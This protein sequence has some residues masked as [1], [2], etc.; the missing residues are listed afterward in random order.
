MCE[1]QGCQL[2]ETLAGLLEH[3]LWPSHTDVP[4]VATTIS[5]TPPRSR[6]KPNFGMTLV[7]TS[8]LLGWLGGA[9]RAIHWIFMMNWM[10]VIRPLTHVQLN[11]WFLYFAYPIICIWL[12]NTGKYWKKWSRW[13]EQ[14][15]LQY[16]YI[17]DHL[18]MLS[19]YENGIPTISLLRQSQAPRG[20]VCVSPR[21]RRQHCGRSPGRST[22]MNIWISV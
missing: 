22:D 19:H 17:Y 1:T 7:W 11:I 16:V 12:Y 10:I 4:E 6:A 9:I 15:H 2:R 13:I 8:N 21:R 14:W 3:P 5:N 20:S 18:W